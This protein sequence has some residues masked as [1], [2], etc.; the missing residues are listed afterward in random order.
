L[1]NNSQELITIK[2]FLVA[3]VLL[4]TIVVFVANLLLLKQIALLN[5]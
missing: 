4:S 2:S 5:S 1:F 3:I